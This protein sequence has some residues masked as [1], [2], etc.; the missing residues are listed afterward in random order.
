MELGPDWQQLFQHLATPPC[1][2]A[3]VAGNLPSAIPSNPL[4]DGESDFI[5]SLEEARLPGATA[6]HEVP[7]MH[8]FLMDQP[9]VQQLV[10]EFL[11]QD[12]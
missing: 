10:F 1:P 8:S 11:T 12:R 7:Y 3:I 2:F 4:V 6:F 5:V 9:Q